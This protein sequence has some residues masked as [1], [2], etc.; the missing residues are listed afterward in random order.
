MHLNGFGEADRFAHEA[1]D[2]SPQVQMLAL[3]LLRMA[4]ANLV[5][6]RIQVTLV[7]APAIGEVARDAKGLQQCFQLKENV[8]L[9]TPEDIGQHPTGAV[10][11]CLP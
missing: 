10:I 8:V 9:T 4:L 11:E 6:I 1:L 7:S 5:L 3:T 2:T